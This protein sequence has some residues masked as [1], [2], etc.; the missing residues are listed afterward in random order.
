MILYIM[1]RDNPCITTILQACDSFS[2]GM[3]V[4]ATYFTCTYSLYDVFR[5]ALYAP[6]A[7]DSYEF[8]G[9]PVDSPAAVHHIDR[10]SSYITS[11]IQPT[12]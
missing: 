2:N 9:V 6:G 7:P 1:I 11:D 8:S 4:S 5:D 10:V 12:C 3:R